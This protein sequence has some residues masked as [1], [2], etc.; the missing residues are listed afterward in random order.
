[1]NGKIA[2]QI[3]AEV[4]ADGFPSCTAE[5]VFDV[6]QHG[7]VAEGIIGPEFDERLTDRIQEALDKREEA[8]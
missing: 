7:S 4:R 8:S 1:M 5:D 6:A 2:E 3:A